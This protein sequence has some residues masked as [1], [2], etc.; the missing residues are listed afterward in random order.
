MRVVVSQALESES[1]M[2]DIEQRNLR[3]SLRRCTKI[4]NRI[5]LRDDK[6]PKRIS[7]EQL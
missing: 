1:V 4:V 3:T 7:D 2:F 5:H 6:Q